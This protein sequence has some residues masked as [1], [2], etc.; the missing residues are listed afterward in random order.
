MQR[1]FP[2][3]AKGL[4]FLSDNF[5]R[6]TMY[7]P[8]N[9][10]TGEYIIETLLFRG[11]KMIDR[12]ATNL[13]VAPV[14]LN[15]QIYE[16]A[17]QKSF[18]RF[19]LC[20]YCRICRMGHKRHPE[21]I[22]QRKG[23]DMS[24][25]VIE[26]DNNTTRAKHDDGVFLLV[27]DKSD[28]F[29]K[30][31]RYAS[32]LADYS[33]AHIGLVY[34]MEQQGFQHWGNIEER[35]REEMRKEAEQYLFDVANS[36]REITGK[37]PAFYIQQGAKTETLISLINEDRT[38]KMLILGGDTQGTPGPLVTYFSGKGLG[39]LRVPMT[40]VPGHLEMSEIDNIF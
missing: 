14:G 38:I 27:A 12:S 34:I 4:E 21:P 40:V 3:E 28:E 33:G 6:A 20:V 5:F 10:P 35:M 24:K 13:T 29:A 18:L 15:A 11:G 8:A 9:V 31:L 32:R 39:Q 26:D 30:A 1:L 22:G 2:L 7:L 36:V 17:T 25:A 19:D 23:R 16:F 37:N